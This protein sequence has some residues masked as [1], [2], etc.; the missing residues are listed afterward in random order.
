MGFVERLQHV[1]GPG[2]D[3]IGQQQIPVLAEEPGRMFR[4]VRRMRSG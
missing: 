2:H 3:Q 4:R 1:H